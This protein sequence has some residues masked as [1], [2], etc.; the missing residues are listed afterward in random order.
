MAVQNWGKASPTPTADESRSTHR[1]DSGESQ[2]VSLGGAISRRPVLPAAN[3][4]AEIYD[5][6]ENQRRFRLMF[7]RRR[8]LSTSDPHIFSSNSFADSLRHALVIVRRQ[9]CAASS[10]QFCS[11]LYINKALPEAYTRV[12]P[13]LHQIHVARYKYHPGRA[14]LVSRYKWIHVAV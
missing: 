1:L 8:L 7:L 13:R 14:T 2:L 9:F 12:K 4:S 6:A 3:Y 11:K 10:K 5:K